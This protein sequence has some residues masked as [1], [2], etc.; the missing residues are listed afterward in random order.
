MSRY[1]ALDGPDGCGKT[2]QAAA[3]VR[4]FAERGERVQH[5]REPGSTPL[6]ERLRELLLS[7]ATGHLLPVTEVLLFSAARAELLQR[8]IAPALQRGEVVVAERSFLATAVYQVLA[9][10]AAERV[11]VDLDWFEDLTRRVHGAWLPDVVFVLDV[12]PDVGAAR[13]RGRAHDRIEARD[14][15]YQARVRAG[16]LAAAAR[17]VRARVVDASRPFEEVQSA[18]R[19][20][21]AEQ[22]A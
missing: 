17:E 15:D 2:S 12:P 1:V 5:V 16:Y 4:W 8:V 14:A 22:P 18:L 7:P 3:L 21:L 19:A 6:G 9:T 20:A 10:P 11:G 13:R